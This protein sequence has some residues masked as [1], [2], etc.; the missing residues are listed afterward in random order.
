M[1]SARRL[2]PSCSRIRSTIPESPSS[3]EACSRLCHSRRDRMDAVAARPNQVSL[4]VA[5]HQHQLPLAPSSSLSTNSIRRSPVACMPR[6]RRSQR[7]HAQSV[8]AK[9]VD[10][11]LSYLA[12]HSQ[13]ACCIVLDILSQ[14]RQP[15]RHPL[16]HDLELTPG[17]PAARPP[18]AEHPPSPP[19]PLSTVCPQARLKQIAHPE[20]LSWNADRQHHRQAR[21]HR[22]RRMFLHRAISRGLATSR[23]SFRTP[24][25]GP[26]NRTI[27]IASSS[28]A[29]LLRS[30]WVLSTSCIAVASVFSTAC[31]KP[32]ARL[33]RAHEPP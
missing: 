5:D 17:T 2:N 1:L 13:P 18:S 10:S 8:A 7:R 15:Q 28:L 27:A 30:L 12:A 29:S 6:S 14:P 33:G 25:A 3:R 22:P 4:P 32:S 16:L 21:D 19:T 11:D 23:H 20:P 31:Q 26:S 24:L 9:P